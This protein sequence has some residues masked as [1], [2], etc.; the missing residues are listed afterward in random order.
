M[1]D[2][3]PRTR[4]DLCPGALRPWPAEDGGL[5]RLRVVGGRI[6]LA[7]LRELAA[8]SARYGDGNVHLT[9]RANLQ[10][11]ALPLEDGALPAEVVEAITA[12]GLLPHPSHE[13][14]RNV[15]VSPLSGISGG[16]ADQ[17]PVARAFDELLCADTAL[18]RLPG[19]FLVVLDDGRGDVQGRRQDLGAMSVD[20][21]HAQLRAGSTGWGEVVP[22]ADV[23]DRLIALAHAF[24]GARGTGET[25][26]WHVD[27]LPE[28]LLDGTRDARTLR[29][30]G[31]LPPG[32][33]DGGIHQEIPDGVLTPEL[34]ASFDD[35]PAE[36]PL[37]VTGWNG[38]VV[39]D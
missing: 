17:Q 33:F 24:L 20:A 10:V 22:L 12:T 32:P 38:I 23:P 13:L 34:L 11:R 35:L 7:G 8:V 28:P 19:R 26:A 15:M 36:H 37:V 6:A 5:V 1:T 2:P 14:V 9:G 39:P 16:V 4:G 3:S 29:N 30:S 18:S 21:Q 27:E 25:A 31:P